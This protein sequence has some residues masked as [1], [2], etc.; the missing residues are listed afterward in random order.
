MMTSQSAQESHLSSQEQQN[1]INDTVL[2]ILSQDNTKYAIK[3]R[4]TV[5]NVLKTHG[6]N[7]NYIMDGAK[8]VLKEVHA[9]Q[10]LRLTAAAKY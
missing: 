2:Y 8:R 3:R 5:K 6:R 9:E 10:F 4:D 1:L 7:C